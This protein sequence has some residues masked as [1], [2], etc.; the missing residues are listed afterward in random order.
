M[1]GVANAAGAPAARRPEDA[2][3]VFIPDDAALSHR[4]LDMDI[5]YLIG[6]YST[7]FT[8]ATPSQADNIALAARRL[9]GTIVQPGGVFSYNRVVGPYTKENGF[10]MGRMF[11]GTRIVPSIG[12]GVCQGAST[13]YNAVILANLEV[14]ERHAHGLTVPYLPPGQDA[15]VTDTYGLDFRFRNNTPAPILI[16]AAAQDRWLTVSLY[17]A[18][19][20]PKVTWRHEILATYSKSVVHTTDPQLPSGIRK[21]V[22]A[23]QDGVRVHSWV[24]VHWPDREEVRDLGIDTYRASPQVIASGP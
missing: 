15:T 11:V 17:G 1:T 5:P 18:Q 14:V 2:Q 20:P 22:A 21:T 4:L 23:G 12:G 13:L 9:N 10:G 7:R 19:P 6:T 8:H 16:R 24:I 3:G